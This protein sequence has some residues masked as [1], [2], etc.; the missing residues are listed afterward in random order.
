MFRNYFRIA[1]RN[2]LKH[3]A[4]S[5]INITGLA[6]GMAC[7]LLILL[8]VKDELGYDR[9]HSNAGSVYRFAR[10]FTGSAPMYFTWSPLP[11]VPA[12]RTEFPGIQT[13]RLA[14][15]GPWSLIQSA[16]KQF[17]EVNIYWA[18]SN[19]FDFFSFPLIYGNPSTALARPNSLVM[20]EEMARKY[21]GGED[22]V[23]KDITI[24]NTYHVAV[25]GV[26]ASIPHNTHFRP[27][28]LVSF[29]TRTADFGPDLLG[30]WGS[31]FIVTYFML[32]P[33]MAL[34]RFQS[35]LPAFMQKYATG[36][37]K[38]TVLHV[39]K[40][41]DIHL[42]SHLTGEFETNGDIASVYIFSAIALF[43]VLIACVNYMNLATARASTRTKEIGIRKTLGAI[44]S[45]LVSQFLVE[46]LV[47]S[48]VSLVLAVVLVEVLLP[49]FNFLTS[50]E[51]TASYLKDP[52]LIGMMGLLW[53][54]VGIVSG[55]YPAL[56]LS[57]FKPMQVLKGISGTG[58][59]GRRL[60]EG[61][62]VLQFVI[63]A[64]LIICTTVVYN[65]MNYIKNKKLGL[66]K[67]HVL[68]V[69]IPDT[70]VRKEFDLIKTAFHQVPGVAG[71]AGSQITPARP[72]VN[73]SAFPPASRSRSEQVQTL[74]TSVLQQWVTRFV[75]VDHD[76]FPV[77]GIPLA[78]GRYFSREYPTDR[79]A[80]IINE[81]AIKQYGWKSAEEAIGKELISGYGGPNQST[82]PIVGVVKDF[83]FESLHEPIKP[84]VFLYRPSSLGSFLVKIESG[85]LRSTVAKLESVWHQIVPNWPFVNRFL[86][87]DYD[88]LYRSEERTG[89]LFSSFSVIAIVIACLGLFGLSAF[90]IEQRTKEIGIRKTLG[91]SIPG[92]V[93]LL[94][95]KYLTLVLIAN[96]IAWPLAYFSMNRWLEDFAYRTDI[97]VG[98]ILLTGCAAILIALLTVSYQAVRAA[99]ANPVE[100]LRYE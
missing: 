32:P 52:S 23:G 5:A 6:V 63:S 90:V 97:G 79:N 92:I 2:L 81:L 7:S 69:S 77:L 4:Y 60:R 84:M 93:G 29:S 66:D 47:L 45:E 20:T 95:R 9:F 76:F 54:V 10:E 38:T 96:L 80:F 44:R 18:D 67:E 83:H 30:E 42:H 70:T 26:I 13:M 71:I 19:F 91:A 55:S 50:K 94:S 98:T 68:L 1:L 86:D 28:F 48:F 65:Q 14:G 24:D 87:D 73:S 61:L 53:L 17:Q 12:L 100:A 82:G 75:S 58:A 16:E 88:A 99:L 11:L 85:N 22:P 59:S 15:N 37:H 31:N 39:Q 35:L 72:L 49:T 46:S 27:D 51:L 89:V 36:G 21:F 34:E 8:Y 56:F 57:R 64:S 3:K 33:D 43:L 40:M 78:A 74:P 25:T 41:T 62:A